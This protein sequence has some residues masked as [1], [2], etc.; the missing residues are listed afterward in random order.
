MTDCSP[1]SGSLGIVRPTSAPPWPICLRKIR[2]A[3]WI[4]AS[5][6]I[7]NPTLK[8]RD[9]VS[10]WKLKFRNPFLAPVGNFRQHGAIPVSE[11]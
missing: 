3:P 8:C 7:A 10:C 6:A 4:Y 5:V 2:A 9:A 11:R 1:A